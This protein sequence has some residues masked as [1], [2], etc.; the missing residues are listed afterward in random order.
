[1]KSMTFSEICAVIEHNMEFAPVEDQYDEEE[2]AAV[3][4]YLQ[5]D[6]IYVLIPW[7]QSQDYFMEDWFSEE[8]ITTENSGIFVPRSRVFF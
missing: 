3:D 4:R 8:A 7:P 5:S 2:Q 6:D 1:M